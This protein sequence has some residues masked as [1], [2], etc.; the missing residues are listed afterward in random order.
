MLKCSK[1]KQSTYKN[2]QV[3]ATKQ[4]FQPQVRVI[5]HELQAHIDL[6]LLH[7]PQAYEN[8]FVKVIKRSINLRNKHSGTNNLFRQNSF[9]KQQNPR[10]SCNETT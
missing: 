2:Y 4:L 6:N 8:R 3:K 9:L 10:T 5:N 1:I 7:G